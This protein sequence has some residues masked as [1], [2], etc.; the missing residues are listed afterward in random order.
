M[1]KLLS[2][3]EVSERLMGACDAQLRILFKKGLLPDR[4]FVSKQRWGIPK[5]EMDAIQAAR[6]RGQND[7]QIREL[8]KRLT[9][10]R[11]QPA[12]TAQEA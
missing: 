5:S 8:V 1:E 7:D 11:T 3:T 2:P 12:A 9:A 4:V 10:Q 6:I